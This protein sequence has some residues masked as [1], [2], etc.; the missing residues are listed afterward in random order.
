MSGL[1]KKIKELERT[2]TAF[3]IDRK[4]ELRELNNQ[5]V[6]NVKKV[7]QQES[8]KSSIDIYLESQRGTGSTNPAVSG[9]SLEEI[10]KE[11]QDLRSAMK[12]LQE[13]GQVTKSDQ[14]LL[15]SLYFEGMKRR[16]KEIGC[17]HPQTFQ[18]IFQSST[19]D[20]CHPI[21]FAE[22]LQGKNDIF[23]IYG[24]PGCGK[25]TL[26]KFIQDSKET[27]QKLQAWS[28][29]KKLV[30]GKYFFWLAGSTLQKSQEGLLRSLLFEIL[31]RCRNLI[32]VAKDTI[33]EVEDFESDEDRWSKDQLL[34]TYEA[35]VSHEF[36]A[37]FCFFIDGLDEYYDS[38]RHPE[39]LLETLRNLR[40]STD[41]KICVS[42]R[43][44]TEFRD[45]FG[46]NTDW[47]LKVEDLTRDD[48]LHY[49]KDRFTKEPQY[50]ILSQDSDYSG[51]IGEV[52]KRAQGV[53]LW[54]VLVVHNL[55]QGFKNGD[56]LNTM[57]ARLDEFPEDLDPFFQHM[58]DSIP[59]IYKR[60]ATRSFEAA[61]SAQRPLPLMLYSFLDDAEKK[62]DLSL[63]PP[64]TVYSPNDIELKQ[65]RMRRQLDGRSKGLL[66]VVS[67]DEET[68]PF[69]RLKVDVLH[70][71][72][73]DFLRQSSTVRRLFERSLKGESRS[74]SFLLCSAI[75]MGMN[76]ESVSSYGETTGRN[77]QFIEDL[78][79]FAHNAVNDPDRAVSFDSV[80]EFLVAAEKCPHANQCQRRLTLE[81]SVPIFIGLAAQYG[82]R[83]YM[84]E[85]ILRKRID[86][87]VFALLMARA[88][89][90]TSPGSYSIH[91]SAEMVQ[92]LLKRG[93]DPN[94]VYKDSTVWL[95]FV[96]ELASQQLEVDRVTLVEI[97]KILVKHRA[98]LS[99]RIPSSNKTAET[100]LRESLSENDQDMIP[101]LKTKHSKWRRLWHKE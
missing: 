31:C 84:A 4:N 22:W 72:V 56:D 36:S 60:K 73:R 45:E 100:V 43:P 83:S 99:G 14:E 62:G 5:I 41:I 12:S 9:K 2:N 37:R 93:A 18:W 1:T 95:H 17:S 81:T 33:R 96:D 86:K 58:L 38:N 94:S 70:R 39:D 21:K 61:S 44:W 16:Y 77:S 26:M 68:D 6:E 78:F 92:L 10:S 75:L 85:K 79:F 80:K 50:A 65:D 3:D 66:Q 46:S 30:I 90:P 29:S 55:V 76:M 67:D 24:K 40:H 54:V 8:K 13:R 51:L 59:E 47:L 91:Y 34:R 57:R 53:F 98:N 89:I 23:W 7:F 82:F 11:M 49:I 35:I 71:T 20:N 87:Y 64:E 32:Q 19:P 63:L 69:W 25:S 97:V 15:K 88:L 101:G 52:A 42:S 28:G 74:T 48:I 27:T